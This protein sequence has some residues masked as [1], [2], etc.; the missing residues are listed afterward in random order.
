MEGGLHFG[1]VVV[2]GI[3]EEAIEGLSFA[4]GP[5]E[6]LHAVPEV[7]ADVHDLFHGSNIIEGR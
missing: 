4:D 2:E 3:A 1:E 6:G 5:A 7:R